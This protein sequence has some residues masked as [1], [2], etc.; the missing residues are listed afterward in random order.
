MYCSVKDNSVPFC[1]PSG[2]LLH[3]SFIS[4]CPMYSVEDIILIH[5]SLTTSPSVSM[6]AHAHTH[7]HTHTNLKYDS[8]YISITC[9]DNKSNQV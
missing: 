1:S 4:L 3:Q 9:K 5:P 6:H 2:L 7:T 8:V